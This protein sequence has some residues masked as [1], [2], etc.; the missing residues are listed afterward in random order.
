MAE[1][2]RSKAE[3]IDGKW[4]WKTKTGKVVE[5]TIAQM[6]QQK[7]MLEAARRIRKEKAEA[8]AKSVPPEPTAQPGPSTSVA[9]EKEKK[10]ESIMIK[11]LMKEF[12]TLSKQVHEKKAAESEKEAKKIEDTED[13]D[14]LIV[15][16]R[17]PSHKKYFPDYCSFTPYF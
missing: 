9:A 2:F 8:A 15:D 1:K 12:K 16:P 7:K 6:D 11:K 14:L 17:N 3:L 13:T 10:P 5:R 4:V